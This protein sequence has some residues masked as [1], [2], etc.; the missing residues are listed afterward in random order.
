MPPP[1]PDVIARPQLLQQLQQGQRGKL[2]LVTAPAGFGK[3]T[4]VSS[5]LQTT[6]PE[7]RPPVA[8]LSLDERDNEPG[9]FW[10]YLLSSLYKVQEQVGHPAGVLLQQPEFAD[11][12]QLTITLLNDLTQHP[13]WLVLDDF[14]LITHPQITQWVAFCID[15]LPPPNH[16]ILTSRSEP[17]LMLARWQ[18][19]RQMTHITEQALRF[20]DEET[21]SLLEQELGA[22]LP[23]ETV[24]WLV[25]KT[26]GWAA[27]LH[28]AILSLR[29]APNPGRWLTELP[30]RQLVQQYLLEEVFVAQPAEIQQFLLHTAL[31]ERFTA[32]LFNFLTG[33]ADGAQL[34][35]QVENQNL[36]LIP[37]DQTQTWYRYHHL[38]ADFLRQR[39]PDKNT[40][41]EQISHW[42]EQQQLLDEA[43]DQ[44]LQ[45]QAYGRVVALMGQFVNQ[46]FR[47]TGDVGQIT[48][49][50]EAIPAGVRDEFPRLY[51]ALGWAKLYQGDWISAQKYITHAQA[52]SHNQPDPALHEEVE[53]TA[54][55]LRSTL[56]RLGGEIEQAI[57]IAH[58]ALAKLSHTEA[59][60]QLRAWLLMSLGAS[61]DYLGD[62]EAAGRAATEILELSEG[63]QN[64][65]LTLQ[66]L[67]G[68]GAIEW[69]RGRLYETAKLYQQALTLGRAQGLANTPAMGLI[70]IGLADVL[71]E[72]YQLDSARFHFEQG[73]AL[74]ESTR[75][76]D[77]LAQ[78]YYGLCRLALLE[79][80]YEIAQ[81][82]LDKLK[83]LLV[84]LEQTQIAESCAAV[85]AEVWLQEGKFDLIWQWAEQYHLVLTPPQSLVNLHPEL[86]LCRAMI[87]HAFVSHNTEKLSEVAEWLGICWQQ[88]ENSPLFLRRLIVRKLQMLALFLLGRRVEAAE[89]LKQV[90]GLARPE[91]VIYPFVREREPMQNLLKE[92]APAGVEEEFVQ[93]ILTAF[94]EE[95]A[96]ARV[97]SALTEPLT[98]REIEILTFLAQGLSIPKIADKLFLTAGTV[99]WHVN[100]IYTKL[101]VH[102]RVEALNLAQRLGL[103]P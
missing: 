9:R 37:L 7:E 5:W 58:S 62:L 95:V 75:L 99:K 51:L 41:Q 90:L 87:R 14:H 50:V 15:Q 11:W 31:P 68:L 66:A 47:Q 83:G 27:G 25:E 49:Y 63:I 76:I 13:V 53:G 67:N 20:A 34:L 8:W 91:K 55:A 18:A 42:F 10:R 4:L 94:G 59:N 82:W 103:L 16:W 39:V 80:Q 12:E 3:T 2:T 6:R 86:M 70:H 56:L 65:F 64:H 21:T 44:A 40:V 88:A 54:L 61:Y 28:L 30:G 85:Q 38:F 35:Q 96:P 97:K 33:R 19:R 102:G 32:G 17:P 84:N 36:F 73:I 89:I 26:E 69:R 92:L 23:A 78:G 22:P 1:R 77:V 43:I 52:I 71:L 100:N 93:Q 46:V 79:Q 98:E 29:Q 72:W 45:A 81:S 101:G 57:Q 60:I 24:N 48:R 74:A